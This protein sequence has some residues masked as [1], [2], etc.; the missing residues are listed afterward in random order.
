[1][2]DVE[3]KGVKEGMGMLTTEMIGF[4]GG[5]LGGF[6]MKAIAQNMA[7]KKEMFKMMLQKNEQANKMANE[8]VKRTPTNF[9]KVTR[10]VIVFV[11]L[12]LFAILPFV[13][14]FDVSTVVE[15]TYKTPEFLW[16]MFGG[17]ERTKF[18]VLNGYYFSESIRTTLLMITGFYFGTAAGTA[19]A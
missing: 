8:A 13:P 18:E 4:I 2:R 16:G 19:K 10:R 11:I 1:M 7:N 15:T 3:A 9:G 6:V 5:S 14:L 17:N 12:G